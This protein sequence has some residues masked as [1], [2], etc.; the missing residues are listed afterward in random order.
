MKLSK[1]KLRRVRTRRGRI[2]AVE[3][4]ES[5]HREYVNGFRKRKAERKALGKRI[6]Q[7]RERESRRAEREQVGPGRLPAQ[8]VRVGI[9]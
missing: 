4:D 1:G 7:Q 2:A 5:A 9:S 3:Y 6:K 8:G